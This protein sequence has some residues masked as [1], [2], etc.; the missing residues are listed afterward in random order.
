VCGPSLEGPLGDWVGL[1]PSERKCLDKFYLLAGQLYRRRGND[2]NW[3]SP[4][5]KL[6]PLAELCSV[7][8]ETLLHA[9]AV[10][11]RPAGERAEGSFDVEVKTLTGATFHY[12]VHSDTTVEEV[13]AMIQQEQGKIPHCD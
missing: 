12:T 6:G 3:L 9:C 7:V 1:H 2:E 4:C 5:T 11:A 13:K 8:G 10:K